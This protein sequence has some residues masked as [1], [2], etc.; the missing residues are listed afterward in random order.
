MKKVGRFFLQLC[1]SLALGSPFLSAAELNRAKDCGCDAPAACDAPAD[2]SC[3]APGCDSPGCETCDGVSCD[4]AA[5]VSCD[6]VCDAVACCDTGCL[7]CCNRWSVLAEAMFLR[8][9]DSG[10]VPL[11][12]DQ[13]T[14]GTLLNANNLQFNHQAVP[15]LQLMHENC[16]CWGWNVGYFGTDSWS[17]TGTGG[18]ED[19]PALVAPG[20]IIGST[21]PHTLY[22][23]G[24]SSELQSFEFNLRRRTHDCWTWVAG[25]RWIELSD[26]L[27]AS[28][29]MPTVTNIYSVD[30]DNHLYGFQV[31]ADAVLL[32]A[33]PRFNITTNF[34]VGILGNSADQTTQAPFLANFNNFVDQ[35]SAS[36]DETSFMAELGVRGV[37][38]LTNGWSVVGGYQLLYLD[39]LA[40]APE[41]VPVTSVL[42][43]GAASLNTDGDLLFHGGVVGLQ[44]TF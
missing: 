13:N 33:T 30:A 21:A 10:S 20:L 31:G 28:T 5:D 15:R 3:A 32:Q 25:F 19:S 42:A 36:G 44:F 35:I 14:G 26:E 43:P 38:Q 18:G 1:L 11:I 8:R 34:R 2:V 7:Q 40:L 37:Y 22:Q 24:Y 23:L 6:A 16:C 12:L 9:S 27:T 17:T 29:I 41:Q 4:I 39:G